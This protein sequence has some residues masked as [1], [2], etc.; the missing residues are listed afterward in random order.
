MTDISWRKVVWIAV[1]VGSYV[2]VV[3]SL[4][5]NAYLRGR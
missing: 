1:F 3:A 2:L 4:L 5:T